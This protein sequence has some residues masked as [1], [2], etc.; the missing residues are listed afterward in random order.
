MAL[1]VQSTLSKLEPNKGGYKWCALEKSFY[2]FFAYLPAN[3]A[4]TPAHGEPGREEYTE[5][6]EIREDD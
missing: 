2:T 6:H 5:D 4:E 3:A 1:A